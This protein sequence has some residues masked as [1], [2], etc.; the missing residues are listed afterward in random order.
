MTQEL[1]NIIKAHAWKKSELMEIMDFCA[2]SVVNEDYIN[3][4]VKNG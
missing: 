1:I 4:E 2:I 3:D